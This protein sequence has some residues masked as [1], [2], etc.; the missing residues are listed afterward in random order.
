MRK[1]DRAPPTDM[2]LQ[3]HMKPIYIESEILR[4]TYC[5]LNLWNEYDTVLTSQKALLSVYVCMS[6]T[7]V[8]AFSRSH[9]MEFLFEKYILYDFETVTEWLRHYATNRKV[10]GSIPDEV[11]F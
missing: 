4:H 2:Q 3:S 8:H 1:V 6:M 9:A 7:C 10:A 5:L 11:N